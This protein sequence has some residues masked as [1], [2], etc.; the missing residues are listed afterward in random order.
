MV[1]PYIDMTEVTNSN[2]AAFVPAVVGGAAIGFV[3][4]ISKSVI[5]KIKENAYLSRNQNSTNPALVLVMSEGI[6]VLSDV[7]YAAFSDA[8]ASFAEKAVQS[9]IYDDFGI[10]AGV[11]LGFYLGRRMEENVEHTA[12]KAYNR[13]KQR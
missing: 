5:G 1:R 9:A 3:Y 10:I 7:L 8:P 12:K 11:L 6:A 2:S 4:G 13:L